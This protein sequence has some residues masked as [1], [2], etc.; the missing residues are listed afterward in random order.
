[1]RKWNSKQARILTERSK[2]NANT[3]NNKNIV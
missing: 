3:N 2:E 1:M